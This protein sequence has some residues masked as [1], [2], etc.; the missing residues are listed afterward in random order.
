MESVDVDRSVD[1]VKWAQP[2]YKAGIAILE[3]FIETRLKIYTDKRNDPTL[4][5]LSNLSPW[6]HFGHI[7]AQRC[8]L[9]VKVNNFKQIIALRF[10]LFKPIFY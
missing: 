8:V 6:L 5:A 2:G 4:N 3:S 7:S 1:E 9:A 10:V